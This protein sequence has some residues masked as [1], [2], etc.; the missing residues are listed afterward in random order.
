MSPATRSA[1]GF[2]RPTTSVD[3]ALRATA[4]AGEPQPLH[5]RPPPA[6]ALSRRAAPRATD[7]PHPPSVLLP[8]YKICPLS[9]D[10]VRALAEAYAINR[11]HLAPWEPRRSPDFFTETGQRQDAKAKVASADAGQQDPWVIWNGDEVVGRVNLSNITRGVFQNASLGYWVDHRHTGR[12]LATAAVRFATQRAADIELHRIEAG[13]LAHNEASQIVLG[14][15]GFEQV[16]TAR[17]YLFIAGAWQ[18]HV[19]F[20]KVLHGRPPPEPLR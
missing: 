19:L 3:A 4:A 7:G 18:D 5:P 14:R 15:C 9:V 6:V 1:S 17:E 12:G 10:D 13:T 16:G 8:G 20:Q 2:A 11:E